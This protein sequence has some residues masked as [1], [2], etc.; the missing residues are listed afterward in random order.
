[1]IRYVFLFLFLTVSAFHLYGCIRGKDRLCSFTK[2]ALMPLLAAYYVLG[3]LPS[4]NASLVAA[5]LFSWIGDVLLMPRGNGWFVAGGI[6]FTAAHALFIPAYLPQIS[7]GGFSPTA[8]IPVS[9]VYCIAAGTVI[10]VIRNSVQR[11]MRVPLFLYLI[12]NGAMN[13]FALMQL[14]SLLSTGAIAVYAGAVLFFV[15]DCT[16]FFLCF[17][18]KDAKHN[19][20]N[21]TVM[22]TYILGEWLITHG[23]TMIS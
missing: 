4:P 10:Y 2:P 6:A 9:A 1:M 16:L 23:M 17:G 13:V 21:F 8:I 14:M 15:S 20:L 18:K 22:L 19:M 11:W 5:L 3:S 7:P 12:C